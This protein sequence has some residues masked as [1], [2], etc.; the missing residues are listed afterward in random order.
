MI[1]AFNSNN[2]AETGGVS[3]R[4]FN[5]NVEKG[6]TYLFVVSYSAGVKSVSLT[7]SE[8]EIE[9]TQRTDSKAHYCGTY[10]A[11][12]T[13]SIPVVLKKISSGNYASVATNFLI[14]ES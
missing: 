7:V 9:L 12:K 5:I 1:F 4:N 14:F 11:N 6:K 13:E 8:S 3:E 2:K 10:I